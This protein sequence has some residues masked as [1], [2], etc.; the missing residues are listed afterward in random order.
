MTLFITTKSRRYEISE[1]YIVVLT[2]CVFFAAGKIVRSIIKKHK[3][4]IT[5]IMVNIKITFLRFKARFK[6]NIHN[7]KNAAK[8]FKKNFSEDKRKPKSKRKSLFLGFTTVLGIFGLITLVPVLPAGAKDVPKSQPGQVCPAPTQQPVQAPSQ[9]IIKG[10][11][12][13][14]A[15]LCA[16]AVTS[17]SFMIEA[18]CGI[19]VVVGIL[20]AQRK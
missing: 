1:I 14:A 17:G 16:L 19:V 10:L 6:E 13:A 11:S 12:G 8:K 18:I 9:Q 15:S 20:K 7:I 3:N 5:K 2:F 4:K